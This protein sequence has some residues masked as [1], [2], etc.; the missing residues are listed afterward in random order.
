MFANG[1]KVLPRV[2]SNMKLH[3]SVVSEALA[4]DV[5]LEW[6]FT[7]VEPDMDLEPVTVGVLARAVTTDKRRLHLKENWFKRQCDFE[8]GNNY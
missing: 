4:T 6:R 1:E 2:S 3:F 8:C 5:A 7:R